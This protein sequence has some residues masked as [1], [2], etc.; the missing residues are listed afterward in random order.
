[1][2]LKA[3]RD[4][5]KA[6]GPWA[7]DGC[8]KPAKQC[9]GFGQ[10]LQ[11]FHKGSGFHPS[12]VAE[13]PEVHGNSGTLGHRGISDCVVRP[14]HHLTAGSHHHMRVTDSQR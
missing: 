7:G 5:G 3:G 12:Q 8:R 11:P 9:S 6:P 14:S 10:V 13:Q 4:G 1:M 2:V